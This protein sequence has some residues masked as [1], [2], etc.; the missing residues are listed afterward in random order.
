MLSGRRPGISLS[1]AG[2]EQAVQVAQVL[3]KLP[4][5]ALYTSPIERCVETAEAIAG[6]SSLDVQIVEGITEVDFGE[7]QG[8]LLKDLVSEPLWKVVQVAPSNAR[9][10][11]GESIREMQARVVG[12]IELIVASH[13]GE[14]VVAVSHADAIKVAVAHFVG[15]HLDLYQRLSIAPASCSVLGFGRFG[16]SLIKLNATGPLDDIAPEPEGNEPEGN[17]PEGKG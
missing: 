12:A 10:P 2:R 4:V 9:F 16:A 7:W 5:A 13:P 17:A 3:A 6:E 8:R 15:M 11:G 1:P 14:L